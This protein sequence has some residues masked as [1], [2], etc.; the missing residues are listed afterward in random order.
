MHKI[1]Q[2]TGCRSNSFPDPVLGE[3]EKKSQ[4]LQTK[5]I[6]RAIVSSKKVDQL[7]AVRAKS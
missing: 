7:N 2:K 3:W 6:E 5:A 4:I 1:L